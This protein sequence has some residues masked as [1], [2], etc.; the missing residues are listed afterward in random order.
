MCYLGSVGLVFSAVGVLLSGYV[1]TRFKPNARLLA[2]WNV[3]V[4]IISVAATLTYPFIGCEQSDLQSN[5]MAA[6]T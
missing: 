2:S 4:A 3:I 6:H 1:I 5:Q